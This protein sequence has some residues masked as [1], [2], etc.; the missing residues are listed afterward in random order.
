[1][2][3]PCQL[4]GVKDVWTSYQIED[5]SSSKV[6]LQQNE[7]L[8]VVNLMLL[9]SSELSQLSSR[10]AQISCIFSLDRFLLNKSFPSLANERHCKV[11]QADIRLSLL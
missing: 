4:F 7:S 1:M 3:P 10:H 11:D 8:I 6:Y 5:S 9:G 2:A